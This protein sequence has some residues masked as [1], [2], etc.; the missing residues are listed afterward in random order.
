[1]PS[2]PSSPHT[3]NV[4][5]LSDFDRWMAG[6]EK[7]ADINVARWAWKRKKRLKRERE[8]E[9][10]EE[11]GR[12]ARSGA[13]R[14]DP[15]TRPLKSRTKQTC[16][17]L[18][19]FRLSGVVSLY[20]CWHLLTRHFPLTPLNPARPSGVGARQCWR[21]L[22]VQQN[23]ENAPPPPPPHRH[24][25]QIRDGPKSNSWKAANHSDR[26]RISTNQHWSESGVHQW[27][28]T[29]R[30][31][32]K[33]NRRRRPPTASFYGTCQ[34]VPAGSNILSSLPLDSFF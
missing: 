30:T 22:D 14:L 16:P 10:K 32:G 23:K 19:P 6:G 17:Y 8:W 20:F 31:A 34:T 15:S 18:S 4:C 25:F 11:K 29:A 26:D 1:M 27:E 28:V 33:T 13:Q 12:V 24:H 7:I 9:K 2:P 21:G 3:T 5:L